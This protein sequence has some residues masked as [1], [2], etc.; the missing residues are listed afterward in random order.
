[1]KIKLVI[2]DVDGLMLNTEV[3]WRDTL[4]EICKKHKISCG[5]EMFDR[6][7][8]KTGKEVE[9][10]FISYFGEEKYKCIL[11]EWREKSN[12]FLTNKIEVKKGLFTLL[13]YLEK[14]DIKKAVAT[15]TSKDLTISRLKKLKLLDRFDYILCGDEVNYKKPNPEIYLKIIEK[16]GVEKENTL[17]LEDSKIGIDGAKA[18]EINCIMIPDLQIPGIDDIQKV[19]AVV[20]SLD[21]VVK[22]ID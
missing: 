8:G 11:D 10:I 7:I 19:F 18:A 20:K 13:E 9:T 6:C 12:E 2:F 21:I 4:F 15:S 1:M 22:I 16:F 5:I 14:K 17:I 3:V